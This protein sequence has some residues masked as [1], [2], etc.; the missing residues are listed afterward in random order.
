MRLLWLLTFT[1]LFSKADVP[2]YVCSF[3]SDFECLSLSQVTTCV[4]LN[5]YLGQAQTLGKTSGLKSVRE[6]QELHSDTVP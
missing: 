4:S 1:I 6:S 3:H 2:S 5:I